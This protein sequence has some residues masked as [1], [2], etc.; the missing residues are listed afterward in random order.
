VFRKKEV[1]MKTNNRVQVGAV[2][3]PRE[4]VTIHSECVRIPDQHQLIHLHFRRFAGCPVCNLHVHS[5]VQRHGEIEAASIR[6]VVVFHSTAEELLRHARD[7]PFAVI[8]DP[9]KQLYAEFGVGSAARALLDPRAWPAIVGGVLRSIG[10]ILYRRQAIPSLN[11]RGGRFGLPADFLIA[12]DGC[13]LVAKYGSHADDQ[14]SVDELLA[15]S[16]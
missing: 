9:G 8:A 14:W 4:L 15:L 13:V 1:I 6:E 16:R 3:E 2:L 10:A 5:I 7:L 11:P 12:S